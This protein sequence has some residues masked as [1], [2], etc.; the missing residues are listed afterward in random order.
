MNSSEVKWKNFTVKTQSFN[1]NSSLWGTS[2]EIEIAVTA[3]NDQ[4]ESSRNKTKKFAAVS[5]GRFAVFVS[6]IKYLTKHIINHCIKNH[7]LSWNT[8]RLL[9]LVLKNL[10]V[11]RRKQDI[12]DL[13]VSFDLVSHYTTCTGFFKQK[14][15]ITIARWF[16]KIMKAMLWLG[17]DFKSV[18]SEASM[19]SLFIRVSA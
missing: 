15:W 5:R 3:V 11:C 12:V 8:V 14:W 19:N 7:K 17:Q 18:F 9:T 13:A 2:Y 10:L 16:W 6:Y 1:F 4:G